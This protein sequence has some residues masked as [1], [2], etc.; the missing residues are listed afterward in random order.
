MWWE[1]TDTT[2]TQ[3]R[4]SED[5]WPPTMCLS[6]DMNH[7]STTCFNLVCMIHIPLELFVSLWSYTLQLLWQILISLRSSCY[8]HGS[9]PPN[10]LITWSDTVTNQIR[11]KNCNLKGTYLF[12]PLT[13][14]LNPKG[15][16][17]GGKPLEELFDAHWGQS[18]SE[19]PESDQLMYWRCCI[20]PHTTN[21]RALCH[22]QN[23]HPASISSCNKASSTT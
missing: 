10:A 3:T 20:I 23:H 14:K 13:V 6:R 11:L 22:E 2:G 21:E 7:R 15:S 9:E 19:D 1:N 18:D 16:G 12:C 8:C 5:C 17:L 4:I